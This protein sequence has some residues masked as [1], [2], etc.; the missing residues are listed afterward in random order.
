VLGVWN[1]VEMALAL[2]KSLKEETDITEERYHKLK[3]KYMKL[4]RAVGMINV[5]TYIVDH[6]R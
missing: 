3:E 1:E 5:N 6:E 4:S 2:L